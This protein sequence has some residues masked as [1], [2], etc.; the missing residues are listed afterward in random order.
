[1]IDRGFI[2]WQPFNSVISTKAILNNLEKRKNIKKPEL[3]PEELQK[4]NEKIMNAY[5][6]K[7]IITL[8]YFEENQIYQ[9][10]TKIKAIYPNYNTVKLSNDKIIAFSQVIKID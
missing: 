8:E 5:Y 7:S 6:D 9:I 10:K 3:F 2:K 4:L 1:M